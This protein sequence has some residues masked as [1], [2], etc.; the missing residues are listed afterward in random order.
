MVFQLR[1]WQRDAFAIYQ[2]KLSAGMRTAL[3]EATPGSGKTSAA[4]EVVLHQLAKRLAKHA[5]IVVPTT[6]L[7]IQ[8][9]RAAAKRGLHLDSSFGSSRAQLSRE[10]QG[11]VVTYQ[12]F[13][14]QPQRFK[15]LAEQAVVILDEVH[16]AGDGLVWGNA[17]QLA[18]GKAPFV[19]CLSG[20]AFRSDDNPIPFVHYDKSGTSVPDYSYNYADAVRDRV[21]RPVAVFTY[22]GSVT[23]SENE[24]EFQ[25]DFSDQLDPNNA[26]KRLRAALDPGSGWIQPLL[27]DAVQMLQS[28]RTEHPSAGGLIAC[29]DQKH[30]RRLAQALTTITGERPTVVLSDDA[31]ASRKIK[32][33]ADDTSRWLVACNMVSEGV[34]IPRL[35]VGIYATTIRTKMYFRQFAGRI[36]RRQSGVPGLQV[37]YLY[38]PADPVLH[39]LAEV[40]VTETR[41]LLN[42][43]LKDP[44]GDED[45]QR[46]NDNDERVRTELVALGS[47]NSGVAAVI[48]QGSQLALFG[49]E[50]GTLAV[51]Q[52]VVSREV[53]HQLEQS[54]TRS[55]VKAKLASE[56]KNLVGLV[57]RRS[58]RPH[59]E[60]HSILNQQQRLRS[61]TYCS[62]EQLRQRKVLL[63]G[64][65][66]SEAASQSNKRSIS[67]GTFS[68]VLK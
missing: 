45:R 1:R 49:N 14:H 67:R 47:V 31:E 17:V 10:F 32:Q 48:V 34:D 54:L 51:S 56:I 68:L 66:H 36:V 61:Q 21:C 63:E 12:Q 9:A 19:L 23:W 53:E 18:L 46:V 24:L 40:I 22:G 30:A 57:H 38:I 25:A 8:W 7:K 4:L 60:I 27:K 43:P 44:F 50:A 55:E 39:T 26:S 13:G 58:G 35:R 16:H 5:L 59:A 41:H 2:E 20:T 37:A 65:L 15:A 42:R 33:F 28:T 52:E 62:E 6:H 64:L 29:A 3:W 11:A